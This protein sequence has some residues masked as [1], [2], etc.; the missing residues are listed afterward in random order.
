MRTRDSGFVLPKHNVRARWTIPEHRWAQSEPARVR[1]AFGPVCSGMLSAFG[2]T[3][4][5]SRFPIPDS[6][7]L[8]DPDL[9]LGRVSSKVRRSNR[10]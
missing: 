3:R 6:L 8:D 2:Y 10:T 9:T 7:L 5:D 1:E 4:L